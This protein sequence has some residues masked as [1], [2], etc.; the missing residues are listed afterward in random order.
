MDAA[1]VIRLAEWRG[2]GDKHTLIRADQMSGIMVDRC[3]IRAVSVG[4]RVRFTNI[5]VLVF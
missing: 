4:T 2:S 1:P 5:R 3:L